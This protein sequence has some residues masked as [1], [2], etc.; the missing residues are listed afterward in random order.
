MLEKALVERPS[1]DDSHSTSANILA[2]ATP[3]ATRMRATSARRSTSLVGRGVPLRRSPIR[4][5]VASSSRGA[6]SPMIEVERKYEADASAEELTRRVEA[7]GGR[8]KGVVTFTDAYYDT[9]DRALC[10][11]DVWLRRRDAAWE[12]KLPVLADARRSGG[13]RSVF[14]EVEGARDVLREFLGALGDDR[15][16]SA[17]AGA[18]RPDP[19]D[20]EAALRD[21]L[22][23]RRA[24]AFA[25]F[26]TTRVKL[27]T[28]SG[29]AVDVD[30]ASFGHVVVEVEVMC[31]DER[32]VAEA[33]RRVEETAR[34]LGLEPLLDSGG[35]LETFIRRNCPEHLATL[36]ERG[37]LK[38]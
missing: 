32:E 17:R 30:A 12:I 15:G 4:G 37:I 11:Q 19:A 16:E 26:S 28:T 38:P 10:A 24:E 14:R 1:E 9:P 29:V 23:S 36:V 31:G 20:A 18:D 5:A 3:L 25:E 21:A 34:E 2:R 7:L 22:A 33:E 27:E 13:E 35:K 8:S 6:S